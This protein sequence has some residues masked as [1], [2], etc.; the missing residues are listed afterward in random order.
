MHRTITGFRRD[1]EGQWVAI[2]EC[3]H[4]QHVRHR[5]PFIERPW[6]MTQEGRDAHIGVGLDCRLCCDGGA[7][8]PADG[9]TPQPQSQT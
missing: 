8:D 2:L 4:S 5:P 3:G 1:D 9:A 6:V 7:R